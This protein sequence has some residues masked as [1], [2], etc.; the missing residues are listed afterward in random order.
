VRLG[1]L[2]GLLW[3]AIAAAP[4]EAGR[5]TVDGECGHASCRF[6][7]TLTAAPGE[8]NAV[9]VSSPAPGVREIH[10][11]GAP[12]TGALPEPKEVP[13]AAGCER[14][15]LHT[16]RCTTPPNDVTDFEIWL[17]IAMTPRSRKGRGSTAKPAQTAW[18][19]RAG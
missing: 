13:L 3:L 19:G 6:G 11:A 9:T 17:A 16:A 4:A 7:V 12:I 10:D 18:S 2:L 5:L 14:V 15:D 1:L 8:R